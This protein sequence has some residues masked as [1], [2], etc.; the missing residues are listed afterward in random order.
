[1]DA[2]KIVPVVTKKDRKEFVE[3]PLRLYKGN[4]YFVP[5]FY[6][7]EMKLFTDKN[8]YAKTC[9][10]SFFLAKRGNKTV[11]RIQGIVQKQY[12]EI[13]GTL[14]ARFTRFDCEDNAETAK[15]L[16]E[17]VEKWA[18][19][20]GMNEMVGPLGYSDLEREGLL[21]EGFDYL[22]TFEEQYN[23]PYYAGLIEN[24]GYVKDVDWL[25]QRLFGLTEDLSRLTSILDRAM[26]KYN[27]H[28]GDQSLG[29][30]K[31]INRYKDGIFACLD[32]CYKDLYG[33]VPFTE[34]MKKQIIEQFTL[35]IDPKFIAVICD[36]ND[37][38]IA[39]GL[40]LPGLGEA[41]QKSGGRLTP[42]C[43][44]RLLKALKHPK[45]VDLA[46]VGIMPKYRNSGLT[47]FM[48]KALQDC[49]NIPSVEYLETNLNLEDN[50]AI[51]STWKRFDHIQHKR[52]RSYIKKL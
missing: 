41:V 43:L 14:Q 48:L 20:Q 27:L 8:I 44:V 33:T 24:C 1:M 2:L 15:A 10:S 34:E 6:S 51:R 26:K 3:Y 9:A 50:V 32:E 36:E 18:Q 16:F 19:E 13:R 29:K 39:F 42:A 35:F 46:L 38:V 7:D 22:A 21:I 31:F 37:E 28:F 5:P 49:L 40:S 47:V 12:N 52:R 11:G 30:K 17:E 45:C 4:P 23:Y 25:E